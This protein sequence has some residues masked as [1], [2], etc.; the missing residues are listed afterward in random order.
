M[1]VIIAGGRDYQDYSELKR[2]VISIVEL[3]KWENIEVVSGGA[4]GTDK[5]GERLASQAAWPVTKFPADWK[6]YG[7]S[8]GPMRNREMANY[9][10]AL[11]AFWDGKSKGTKNMIEEANRRNLIVKVFDY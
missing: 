11:I 4:D 1:K 9:A 2:R 5:M 3:N 10:D 7:K 6:T 8:A